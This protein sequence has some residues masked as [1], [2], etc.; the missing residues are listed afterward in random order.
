MP[1]IIIFLQLFSLCRYWF[2]CS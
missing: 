1:L 2:N